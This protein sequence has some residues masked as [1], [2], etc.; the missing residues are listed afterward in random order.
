MDQNAILE[1]LAK[2]LLPVV[3]K[4]TTP[5][6][7]PSNPYVHG[8]GGLFGVMGLEREVIHTRLQPV[9]L[10][11]IL[12]VRPSVDMW[13]LFPYISGFRDVTGDVANGVC[14]D[15]QTAGPMKTCLQTAPFGRYSFMTREMEINRVGQ[16]INRGEFLDL[17][18]INSPLAAQ[19]GSSIFPTIP[20]EQ[21]AL[22]GA[23]VLQRFI[24]VGVAFQNQLGRQLYAA[25]PVNDSAGGGYE[26]FNGLD[27]LIGTG[28]VD[29]KTAIACPSLDSIVW[30][31]NL[32]N[33]ASP[34]ANPN[35]VTL[36]TNILRRLNH[37]ATRT[38]LQP[39][40]LTLAMR[41]DLF[42]VITDLWACAYYSDRCQ[43]LNNAQVM[44]DGT[45]M[46]TI[47]DA[48]RN[49]EY[50][51]VDGKKVPVVIDDM[52]PEQSSNEDAAIPVGCFASDIYIVPLTARGMPVTYFEHFDYRG[53]SM[54][55]VVD[56]RM[57]Q[58][59]W[60]D[61]G[62]FLW[63]AKPPLNWCVQWLGKIEPRLVLRTPHLSA[64]ILDVLYCPLAH[65]R[66]THP[67]DHYWIDGGVTERS[68]DYFYHE[69][70]LP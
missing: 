5:T 40:V 61:G 6:G 25:N 10:A 14:D 18:L 7:T 11:G 31:Y 68:V 3:Q 37:I 29:A 45:E 32:T 64:R 8:P 56:G 20:S 24:E 17:T 15:P 67:D 19:L 41:Q 39:L 55:A 57:T 28:K 49:G 52:I 9:G 23:E 46:T 34:T 51:L 21:Q 16:V 54:Q 43:T 38:G 66:D 44:L 4:H 50:L 62:I 59:F 47:R 53:G 70:R 22:K 1:A 65:S 69:G 60:T 13:P 12:P 30:D 26:E 35:I 42:W 36:L 58:Y 48:M 33:I 2:A 27:L 63:H